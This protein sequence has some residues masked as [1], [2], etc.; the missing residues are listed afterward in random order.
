MTVVVLKRTSDKLDAF[1]SG[2]VLLLGV[3]VLGVY[4]S[5]PRKERRDLQRTTFPPNLG[6]EKKCFHRR[7]LTENA[8][9]REA[10]K[11]GRKMKKKKE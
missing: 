2:V 6:A 5:A 1:L 10:K 11:T 3:V 4:L 7:L 9:G 8:G